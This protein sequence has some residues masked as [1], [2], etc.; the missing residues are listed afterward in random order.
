MKRKNVSFVNGV[1]MFMNYS[2]CNPLHLYEK[3]KTTYSLT[4]Q[5]HEYRKY[6]YCVS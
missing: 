2:N 5:Y 1:D 3:N 6:F 4:K